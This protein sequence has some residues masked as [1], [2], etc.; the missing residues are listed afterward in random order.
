V[1]RFTPPVIEAGRRW[2][3]AA[4]GRWLV[5]ETYLKV[6]GRWRYPY[7]AVDQHGQVIDVHLSAGGDVAAARRVVTAALACHPERAEVVTDLA[8]ALAHVITDLLPEAFHN[9][10]CH[11]NDRVECDHGRLKARLR[12]RRGVETDGKAGVVVRGHAFFQNLRRH[13]YELGTYAVAA[14]LTVAAAF[15]ELARAM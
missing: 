13:H 9:T 1:Q 12:P 3:H 11:A 15:D 2:R 4:G 5:D 6:A 14:Q 10:K 7:R 8:P